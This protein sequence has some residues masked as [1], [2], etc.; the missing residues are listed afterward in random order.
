MKKTV[1]WFQN[2]SKPDLILMDIQLEDGLCFELF[3]NLN[4]KIPVIFTTAFDEFTLKAFKVNSIDYLLKPVNP[5]ELKNALDKYKALHKPQPLN[6]EAILEKLQPKT[7]ERFLIRIG[8]H[9]RSVPVTS[10]RCFYIRERCNF[11]FADTGKSYPIDQSLDKIEHMLERTK[12]FRV[13][14]NFIVQFNAIQDIIAYSSSRLKIIVYCWSDPEE[15]L[16]SRDRVSDFK[17]W[18]D[19]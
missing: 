8:D 4:I 10:I 3:E 1:N 7:K 13:N 17:A 12:F 16:V 9:Y 14:R 11:L 19:R 18:M 5:A 15:I 6:F 2:N